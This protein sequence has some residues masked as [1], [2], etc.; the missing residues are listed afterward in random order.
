MADRCH[1]ST[2]QALSSPVFQDKTAFYA[3]LQLRNLGSTMDCSMSMDAHIHRVKCAMYFHLR[4]I[5]KIRHFLDRETSI[6]S[7]ISLIMSRLDSCNVLLIGKSAAAL[8]GL[9]VA[10]NYAAQV[11]TGL[12]MR[13]H[14][15]PALCDLHWLP[16]V[17]RVKHKVLTMVYRGL[18]SNDA[19]G[20]LRDLVNRRV[21]GRTLRS[22]NTPQLMVPRIIAKS[23]TLGDLCFSVAA[24]SMYNH[25]PDD[26][27]EGLSLVSFKRKFKTQLFIEHFDH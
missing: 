27:R 4:A 19:P 5:K 13:D 20:Y 6:K 21:V 16:V 22:S 18:Y 25:L 14:I 12:G 15:S 10:Q 9:Q 3:S 11:I 24:P 17:Q 26:M 2:L 23:K 7:V 1:F 8:R